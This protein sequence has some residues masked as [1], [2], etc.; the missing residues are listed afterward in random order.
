MEALGARLRELRRNRGWTLEELAHEAGVH[1]THLSAV[2]R[3]KRNP[4]VG[5]LA[6]RADALEVDLP[7]FFGA[8]STMPAKTLRAELRRR[9]DALE[10]DE[11]ARLLRV[12]DALR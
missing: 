10:A 2:E 8:P 9:T 7:A 3:G 5:V 12:V 4:T 1:A 11:L 6:K